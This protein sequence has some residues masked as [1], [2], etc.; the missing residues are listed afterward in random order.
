MCFSCMIKCTYEQQRETLISIK[1]WE[2]YLLLEVKKGLSM[3]E[4]LVVNFLQPR[5]E[6]IFSVG[7]DLVSDSMVLTPLV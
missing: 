6:F 7:I 2:H 5:H 4:L 3:G 1:F